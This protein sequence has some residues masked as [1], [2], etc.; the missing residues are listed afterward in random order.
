MKLFRI[1]FI[2]AEFIFSACLYASLS[3]SD[4]ILSGLDTGDIILRTDANLDSLVI[5]RVT[6]AQYSHIGLV[7]KDKDLN[8]RILE[9]FPV[10][11]IVLHTL[12][13]FLH[14]K[15]GRTCRLSILRFKEAD[16]TP[17][18]KVIGKILENS[19]N[20]QFDMELN[21]DDKIPDIEAFQTVKF[22]YYCT[23]LVNM[24]F[25]IAYGQN[26]LRWPNDYDRVF[27]HMKQNPAFYERHATFYF[28]H[29]Q[30]RMMKFMHTI[31]NMKKKVLLTP[32]G[33]LKSPHFDVIFQGENLGMIPDNLRVFVET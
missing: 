11:G 28:Q 17:L 30:L 18:N 24:I 19:T 12:P 15:S 29:R 7:Y 22:D 9:C 1:I 6:E 21:F 33:I 23:E 13:N 32:G 2:L 31:L 25:Q 3:V 14:P 27:S 10:K 20:I 8:I 26:Y 16:R 4:A 5:A